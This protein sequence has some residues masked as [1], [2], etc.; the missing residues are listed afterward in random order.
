M[1]LIKVLYLEKDNEQPSLFCSFLLNS[2][3]VYGG[4]CFLNH[5]AISAMRMLK[6]VERVAILDGK[7]CNIVSCVTVFFCIVFLNT[8]VDYHYGDGTAE[9]FAHNDRVL[10]VSIHADPIFDYPSYGGWE[11]ENTTTN[12]NYVF[13]CKATWKEY[14]P[15]LKMALQKIEQ[16]KP[17][18]LLV[19]FGADTVEGDPDPS[20]HYGCALSVASYFDMGVKVGAVCPK[21]LVTQ[22]GGYD[23]PKV[24]CI[25]EK[26]LLGLQAAHGSNFKQQP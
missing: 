5:A 17:H 21:I 3:Q 12:L 10:T 25:V 22:E 6:T 9:V 26:F 18:V 20:H 8:T 1:R 19:A 13:P 4:Y 2:F 11:N 7:Q 24:P 23:L 14:K 16:F 15:I